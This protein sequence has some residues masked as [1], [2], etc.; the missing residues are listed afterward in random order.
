[1]LIFTIF[2]II[3]CC[4][5]FWFHFWSLFSFLR[6]R[7]G[8]RWFSSP[9]SSLF[10]FIIYWVRFWLGCFCTFLIFLCRRIRSWICYFCTSS[11]FR[12]RWIWLSNNWLYFRFRF[13][14]WFFNFVVNWLRFWFL[15]G[16]RNW[17]LSFDFSSLCC[18]DISF[19]FRWHFLIINSIY[20]Q[21]F[22][23]NTKSD[24]I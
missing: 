17:R 18:F 19:L 14:F 6:I 9:Y 21:I 22:N 23:Y 15:R 12:W 16:F 13:R 2:F 5:W 11:S 20:W 8:L 4:S 24:K 3:I 10:W 1:M 7:L